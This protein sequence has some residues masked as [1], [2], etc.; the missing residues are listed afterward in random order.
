M[1]TLQKGFT[2]IETAIVLAIVSTL[3]VGAINMYRV[4]RVNSGIAETGLRTDFV[5]DLLRNYLA[6]NGELPCPAD[7]TLPRTNVNYGAEDCVNLELGATGILR[8]ALPFQTLGVGLGEV[9]DGWAMQFTYLVIEEATMPNSWTTVSWAPGDVTSY[10]TLGNGAVN[11]ITDGVVAFFSHGANRSGGRTRDGNALPNPVATAINELEN[12]DA[13]GDLIAANFSDSETTPFDD[14]V[15]VL[16]EEALTAPLVVSGAL[17]SKMQILNDN[18]RT[19]KN[20]VYSDAIRAGFPYTPPVAITILSSPFGGNINYDPAASPIYTISAAN[21]YGI[22]F[23]V[24]ED[25]VGALGANG[26][27]IDGP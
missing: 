8:G 20:Q 25:I 12:I 16:N 9:T 24:A 11:L 14:V 5:A 3:A 4:Q 27:D 7:P 2:L 19:M 6:Q 15:V 17:P 10:I 26:V 13:D 1:N 22:V 18:I 23:N 21:P